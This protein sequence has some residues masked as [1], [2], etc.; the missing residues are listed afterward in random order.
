MHRLTEY[1][2]Q[3]YPLILGPVRQREMDPYSINVGLAGNINVRADQ[4]TEPLF[5]PINHR[6]HR[7]DASCE[8]E[9]PNAESTHYGAVTNS[10]TPSFRMPN[11]RS[12]REPHLGEH[13]L[14]E[15]GLPTYLPTL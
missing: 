10:R 2:S 11:I 9:W 3:I 4:T 8:S 14:A 15:N 7:T 12:R 5:F 13:V 6:T 1:N